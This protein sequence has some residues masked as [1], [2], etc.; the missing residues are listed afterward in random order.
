MISYLGSL[1]KFSPATGSA[2]RWRQ[3]SLCMDSTHCVLA[4]LGLLH[5]GVSV[6]SLSTL[7]RLPA[8]LY[9]A[10]PTLSAVP[11]FRYST[12]VQ[13][14]LRL[15]FL[16]SMAQAVQAARGLGTLSPDAAR[17]FPPRP[18]RTPPV[19]CLWL[20]LFSGAGL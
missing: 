9:G 7:L 18:Q 14:Q 15:R 3:I 10:G 4:T 1:V 2:G 20:G 6:L 11:V 12:K 5:T 13:I 8:A 19:G 17:L 16:P